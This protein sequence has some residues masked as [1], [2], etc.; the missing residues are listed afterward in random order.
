MKNKSIKAKQIS[1]M[2]IICLLVILG[3]QFYVVY[4]YY[5]TTRAGLVR[6]SDAILQET[7]KKDLNVRRTDY[8][9]ITKSDVIDLTKSKKSKKATG[10]D[11]TN[12]TNYVSN[13]IDL[14]DLALNI[15]V[16]KVIPINIYKLDSI[17]GTILRSR[18]INSNYQ[19]LIIEKESGKTMQQAKRNSANWAVLQIKS[20]L[21]TIDINP[22]I[23]LQLV[24]INPFGILFK[25]MGLMLLTSFVFS[26]ICLLAFG[27]LQ[28]ILSRQK[29][30]VAFKNEF[31]STI[32]HELK[33]PVASLSYNLDCMTLP[34]FRQDATKHDMLIARSVIATEEMNNTINMIVAL[35][36]VEEGLLQLHKEP[37]NLSQLFLDL[38]ERFTN[39]QVKPM[40][41]RTVFES[42]IDTIQADTRL[43]T[44]CF[45]NLIDNSIKYSGKE[46]LIVINI[47][48]TGKWIVISIKDNGFGIAE[49]KLPVIFD[50][51]I[52]LE[53]ANT[54]INGFG[55]GLNYVK[56]IVENHKGKVEVQ[57][58]S[59]E[60]TEFNVLLPV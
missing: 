33:R 35:A 16:S 58:K 10:Y 15:H 32:T 9:K 22:Q 30:L 52:R 55:I 36:K 56:T 57:S 39:S 60:G 8:N 13:D 1:Y 20:K 17:T 54:K 59:G 45:A 27:L 38:K 19:V 48:Q 43:L 44:Q 7:F 50:K 37:V 41:I 2:V 25:R 46:V 24:L 21:L 23:S 49:E 14:V 47:R 26:I 11:F 6:E 4:D 18:N 42:E 34:G 12:K 40:E 29:Q 53:T 51:Y 31:L 5:Q 3:A 28:R